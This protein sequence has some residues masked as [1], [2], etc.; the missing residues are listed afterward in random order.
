MRDH[1]HGHPVPLR[2][3][4]TLLVLSYN[5]AYCVIVSPARLPHILITSINPPDGWRGDD[6]KTVV[7]FH[8]RHSASSIDVSRHG[9]LSK[10]AH[11]GATV[12]VSM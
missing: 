7:G 10:A 4:W 5:I 1:F 2:P 12:G 9:S 11:Q 3:A 8:R 6:L